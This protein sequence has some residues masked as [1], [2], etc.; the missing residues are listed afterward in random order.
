MSPIDI[1]NTNFKAIKGQLHAGRL[2]VWEGFRTHG[3]CTTSALSVRIGMSILTV[4][5]RTTELINL[6][7]VVLQERAGNEGVYAALSEDKAR[8][9]FEERQAEARQEVQAEMKFKAAAASGRVSV[10]H[11]RIGQHWGMYDRKNRRIII[12]PD[13]A[14][15]EMLDT[16]LHE[17]LHHVFPDMSEREVRRSSRMLSTLVWGQNYRKVQQ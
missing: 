4:R 11:K 1:R 17:G 10:I 6:G 7:F 14:P 16:L 9:L 2:Q 3:P 13:Q 12:H 8:E 5:P 15:K